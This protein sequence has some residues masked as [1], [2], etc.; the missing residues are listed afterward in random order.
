ME[1]GTVTVGNSSGINDGASA[2]LIMERT[3]AEQLGFR[4]M[5]RFVTSAVS[6]V[7]SSYIGN[8]PLNLLGI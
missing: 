1:G 7:H 4:P 8:K 3:K 6:G 2:I 5:A